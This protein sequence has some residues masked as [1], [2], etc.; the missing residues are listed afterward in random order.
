MKKFRLSDPAS[1]VFCIAG[2]ILLLFAAALLLLS[3]S[4]SLV[5]LAAA[6]GVLLLL[7]SVYTFFV[8]LSSLSIDPYQK[9]I[10]LALPGRRETYDLKNAASAA[11]RET[12]L[13]QHVSRALVFYDAS[14]AEPCA[15]PTFVAGGDGAKAEPLAMAVAEALGLPFTPTVDAALYDKKARRLKQA[16]A[17][18]EE[19]RMRA[20][21]KAKK[22]GSD[23]KAPAPTRE[24]TVNYDEMDDEK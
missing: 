8:F 10:T 23:K 19:R 4:Q 18:E 6:C 12:R 20:Q 3:G 14:G 9:I 24:E 17:R 21:R 2:D 7:L 1:R 5:L 11:T 16:A 15:I 22:R 13:E